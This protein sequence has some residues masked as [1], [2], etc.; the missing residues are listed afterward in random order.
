VLVVCWAENSCGVKFWSVLLMFGCKLKSR[1]VKIDFW[2]KEIELGERKSEFTHQ[3][4]S[5][6][7]TCAYS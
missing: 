7:S 2:P 4:P 1:R 6:L 3:L 5:C